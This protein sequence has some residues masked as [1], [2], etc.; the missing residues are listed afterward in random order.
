MVPSQRPANICINVTDNADCDAGWAIAV[1][2]TGRNGV[3]SYGVSAVAL[4]V[5]VTETAAPGWIAVY[6]CWNLPNRSSLNFV[7]NDTR[8]NAVIAPVD[9]NGNVCFYTQFTTH[10][11]VDVFGYLPTTL[12]GIRL[13]SQDRIVDTR[14]GTGGLTIGRLGAGAQIRRNIDRH[15]GVLSGYVA[16]AVLNVTVTDPVAAGYVTVYPCGT[17][18]ATS[19]LNFSAGQTVANLVIMPVDSNGDLCLTSSVPT[20]VIVDLIAWFPVSTV[21]NPATQTLSPGP[22]VG[23]FPLAPTRSLDTRQG[24]AGLVSSVEVPFPRA[25]PASAGAVVYNLTATQS[26]RAG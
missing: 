12:N 23:F 8:A 15:S 18:P 9:A 4:N 3:P 20:H 24:S 13:L 11:V 14:E 26:A 1:K 7:A 2:V 6:P 25:V 10:L 17:V 5:T 22:P 19:S 21:W 16:G